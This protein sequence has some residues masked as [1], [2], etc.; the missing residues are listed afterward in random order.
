MTPFWR[1]QQSTGEYYKFSS[2]PFLFFWTCWLNGRVS[3]LLSN[4]FLFFPR[5]S[6]IS[7]FGPVAIS[8]KYA[9]EKGRLT[10]PLR[11]KWCLRWRTTSSQD[12][13]GLKKLFLITQI[14]SPGRALA[15]NIQ[16]S[17]PSALLKARMLQGWR[18]S[19]EMQLLLHNKGWL[20][21]VLAETTVPVDWGREFIKVI[22]QTQRWHSLG[23]EHSS[24]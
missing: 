5:V 24:N 9:G 7:W 23:S 15:Q 6:F 17:I 4:P 10:E 21:P 18:S 20:F 13:V 8:L 11:P 14:I 1:P 19:W 16:Q 12:V 2:V 3:W 22:L